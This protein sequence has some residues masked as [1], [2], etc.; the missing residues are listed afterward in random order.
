MANRA[1]IIVGLRESGL[2]PLPPSEDRNVDV[3]GSASGE[4]TPSGAE[5]SWQTLA[6]AVWGNSRVAVAGRRDRSERQ[7]AVI[8]P[9]VGIGSVTSA[10]PILRGCDRGGPSSLQ[11]YVDDTASASMTLVSVNGDDT[12]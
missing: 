5:H 12:K 4:A 10:W 9:E 8:Q 7:P 6:A 2:C 11:A 3:A 1:P